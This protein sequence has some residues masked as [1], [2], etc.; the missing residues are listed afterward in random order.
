MKTTV[1]SGGIAS[2]FECPNVLPKR[3]D[4]EKRTQLR[5]KYERVCLWCGRI[6]DESIGWKIC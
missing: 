2:R 6:F 4:F 3:L 5:S 1:Q